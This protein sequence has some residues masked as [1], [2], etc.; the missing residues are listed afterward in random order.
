MKYSIVFPWFLQR[1]LPQLPVLLLLL[2]RNSMSMDFNNDNP[3]IEPN[4]NNNIHH[5]LYSNNGLFLCLLVRHPQQH[6][7][8]NLL[9]NDQSWVSPPTTPNQQ[10]PQK[11]QQPCQPPPLRRL[12]SFTTNRR[13]R[14]KTVT[15]LSKR[16]WMY[17][18]PLRRQQQQQQH[19]QHLWIGP[20]WKRCGMKLKIRTKQNHCVA[21][22]MMI[23]GC[24]SW[25]GLL[26][27]PPRL[28]FHN[29]ILLSNY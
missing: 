5:H 22:K 9:P 15:I 18:L 4:I 11:Q 20:R 19:Q 23:K 17:H 21:F 10:Q 8:H 7:F 27:L 24:L 12:H 13:I 14:P 3:N 28:D 25:C 26:W 1:L 16:L 2:A 6:L 29:T